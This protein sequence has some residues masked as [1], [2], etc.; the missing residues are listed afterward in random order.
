MPSA[1]NPIIVDL[2][3]G[4]SSETPLSPDIVNLQQC[5]EAMNIDWS[6]G[7]IGRRRGGSTQ[8]SLTGGTAPIYPINAMTRFVPGKDE[9]AAE[10]WL[11]DSAATPLFKRLAGGTAWADVNG[12][13]DAITSRPQDTMFCTFNGKL[14][15]A[16]TSGVDRLHVY[17][18]K[19]AAPKIRRVGLNAGTTAPTVADTGSGSYAATLRYYRQR[20][21]RYDAGVTIIYSESEPT[22]SVSF[23]PG[24]SSLAARVTRAAFPGEGETHWCV[25]ASADN[26]TFY[27]ISGPIAVATTTY[28]DSV[29]IANYSNSQLS[30]LLGTYTLPTS[31]RFLVS[32]GNR[33]I[34]AGANSTSGQNSRVWYT[35]VLGSG[36]AD[37]ERIPTIFASFNYYTDVG[38]N[39]G[40]AI[41]GLGGPGAGSRIYAFKYRSIWVLIPTGDAT[42]P[43]LQRKFAPGIGAINQQSIVLAFDNQGNPVIYFLS[44]IGPFRISSNG[45]EFIGWDVRDVWSTVNLGATTQVAHGVFYPKLLQVWWWVSVGTDNEPTTER[46]IFDIRQGRAYNVTGEIRRGWS[47]F[48]GDSSA[49]RCSMLFSS[50]VGASMSRGL[51]PYV[52]RNTGGS[53]KILKCDTTDLND[54]GVPFQAYVETGPLGSVLPNGQLVE[55]ST[56][57]LTASASPGQ[58]IQVAV[59]KDFGKE[60]RYGL[61]DLT[62][63]KT[64]SL[65]IKDVLD[66][67]IE[68]AR[69]VQLTI[70]DAQAVD[71][72]WTLHQLMIPMMGD[73]TEPIV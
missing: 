2:R 55:L 3:G 50:T 34:G 8:L 52:G 14:F 5:V 28:D 12:G 26:S 30:D 57:V 62:P 51:V 40:G 53:T 10:A 56:P 21:F 29:V 18:P 70:G 64:E 4:R 71:A 22:N 59:V 35:P 69:A 31:M 41:T 58:Q 36:D 11:L 37:D 24:G 19:D 47:R 60:I 65:V 1:A 38:E 39:D 42:T 17:S 23:T 73:G 16:F 32:D 54:D 7:L 48:S 46:I 27:N 68:S 13:L 49:A 67:E 25:E 20:V 44:E 6:A 72:S 33:L 45:L 9:T 43:Y 61:V 63:E 15:V 66:C